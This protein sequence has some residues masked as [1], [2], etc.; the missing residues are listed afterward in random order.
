MKIKFIFLD[1]INRHN[2]NAKNIERG[3]QV[4]AQP[5]NIKAKIKKSHS[6]KKRVK[7]K[8]EGAGRR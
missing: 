2:Q 8:G 4:M 6:K 3:T 7:Q 1:T 5:Q